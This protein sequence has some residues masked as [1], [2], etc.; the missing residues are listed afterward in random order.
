MK[1]P[2]RPQEPQLFDPAQYDTTPHTGDL[3]L[4]EWRQR[5]DVQFHGT[6]REDFRQAPT[7]H[8]GTEAQAANRMLTVAR[9][10]S[11]ST[12]AR[13]SY[14]DPTLANT[15]PQEHL[16]KMHAFRVDSP[17]HEVQDTSKEYRLTPG[18]GRDG[19]EPSA[20]VNANAAD[21]FHWLRKGYTMEEVPA[22]IRDSTEWDG[23]SYGPVK[24]GEEGGIH[25]ANMTAQAAAGARALERGEALSYQNEHE[26]GGKSFVAR[27]GMLRSW[28]DD[29]LDSPNRSAMAKQY[30]QQRKDQG[31]AGTV[32]FDP[33]PPGLTN[34]AVQHPLDYTGYSARSL[35]GREVVSD[36]PILGAE[37]VKTPL[38]RRRLEEFRMR[39]N[40]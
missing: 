4:D 2:S 31:R 32:D 18:T 39:T 38:P 7:I 11:Q 10:L 1:G 9:Q 22:S 8:L 34:Y 6:F 33:D 16:G 13:R 14:Y 5:P 36:S 19:E 24:Y 3:P 26:G 25:R 20:D 37:S 15:P 40:P 35:S 12:L 27:P 23:V 30:A 29:V 28:E 17:V 21:M